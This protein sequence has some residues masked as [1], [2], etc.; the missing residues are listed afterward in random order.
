M[1]HQAGLTEHVPP[2]RSHQACLTKQVPPSMSHQACLT[3]HVSPSMSHQA[4]LTKQVSPSR[5]HQAGP[6]KQVLPSR[7]YQVSHEACPPKCPPKRSFYKRFFVLLWSPNAGHRCVWFIHTVS[8]HAATD[9]EHSVSSE[10]R[11]APS[12]AIVWGRSVGGLD[13]QVIQALKKNRAPHSVRCFS[14]ASSL[15]S[16]R[17]ATLSFGG[18]HWTGLPELRRR[19][20]R[21]SRRSPGVSQLR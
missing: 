9:S 12:P 4:C 10:R 17:K 7:S 15:G 18:K 14:T 2:S 16:V 21:S 8:V 19:K 3:K 6:T 13:L 5:S 11:S 1:S 20:P